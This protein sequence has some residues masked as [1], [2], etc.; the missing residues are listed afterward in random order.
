MEAYL[1]A[2]C[3]FD[4]VDLVFWLPM[5]EF[6]YNNSRKPSTMMRVFEALLGYHPRMSYKDNCD[7][8]SKP[9]TIDEN[10]VILRDLMKPLKVNLTESQELQAFHHNNH[11]MEHTYRPGDSV[12]SSGKHI[13]T[14]RNLK[15]EHKYLGLFE[16]LQAVGKQAYKFKFFSKWRIHSVFHVSLLERLVKRNEAVDLKIADQL[17]FEEREK[18]E[19]EVDS[20]I[21]RM[22]F[23]EEAI[24]SQT[25]RLYYIIHWKKATPTEDTWERVK[26][27]AHLRPLLKKYHAKNLKKPTV[28]SPPLVENACLPLMAAA[29]RLRATV[30]PL[31]SAL[32]R[33]LTRNHPPTRNRPHVRV[34]STP[35][36]NQH[37]PVLVHH[38]RRS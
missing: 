8:R 2:Y 4:Q 35:L 12:W 13:K 23:A 29:A 25:P 22:I 36:P 38:S 26:G 3:R 19:Q 32:I 15:L 33:S 28:T 37:L 1:R 18:P 24:D 34:P 9:R 31:T 27:I 6:A 20:I 5:A 7:P 30:A 10:S 17:E 14:K 21:D 16:I 11:I